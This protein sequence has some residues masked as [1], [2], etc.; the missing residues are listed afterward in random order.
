M[1]TNAFYE[2]LIRV[3][4]DWRVTRVETDHG[5]NQVDVYLEYVPKQAPSPETGELC[6]IYDYRPERAWR[7]LDTMQYKTYLHARVPRVL[8]P[9]GKADTITVP[10]S[11]GSSRQSWLFEGWAIELLLVTKN[12]RQTARLLDISW[13]QM[14]RI[15]ARAVTRGLAVRQRALDNPVTGSLWD[16]TAVSIDEKAYRYGHRFLTILS[17]PIGGQVLEIV[18]GRTSEATQAAMRAV[19]S[20]R[21]LQRIKAVSIDMCGPFRNAVQELMPMAKIVY[22]KFHLVK[23]LTS[24][25]DLTRRAE[26]ASQE[27][28]KKTKY[29]VMKNEANRTEK[30]Q[31][32]FELIDAM[33]LKTSQA[34]RVRENFQAM[35]ATCTTIEQAKAFVL[36]WSDRAMATGIP[37]IK[38]VAKTFKLHLWGITSYFE[39]SISNARAENIN[40]RIQALKIIGRGYQNFNNMRNAVLFF[41]GKLELFPHQ[42]A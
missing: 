13:G 25:I 22:D 12:Q 42:T 30:E 16:I 8:L 36:E 5:K 1:Q 41:Y 2:S 38:K 33:N 7:H 18:E 27:I 40:G 24:A 19:L 23:L 26:V 29:L 20:E 37:A 35:Y 11:D 4:S 17:T 3:G 15:M 21:M 9:S 14:H 32:T 39:S 6:P 28:L 34:W 31:T 10:W